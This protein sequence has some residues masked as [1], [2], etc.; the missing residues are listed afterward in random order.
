MTWLTWGWRRRSTHRM[1]IHWSEVY[2][3]LRDLQMT[4]FV[5]VAEEMDTVVESLHRNHAVEIEV[6]ELDPDGA[7]AATTALFNELK[8]QIVQKL[9]SP[10]R[11]L[12]DVPVED[13]IRSG[14]EDVTRLSHARCQSHHSRSSAV[15][16]R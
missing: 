11:Q 6:Q 1:R 8:N 9:F 3:N 7:T 16:F 2:Q 5:F 15:T 10:P 4:N 13:R 12:G 14:G